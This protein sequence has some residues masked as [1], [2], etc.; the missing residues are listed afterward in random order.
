MILENSFGQPEPGWRREYLE[1]GLWI[2]QETE[3]VDR[4]DRLRARGDSS[5]HIRNVDVKAFAIDVC[6]ND[7][8]A[9]S[10]NGFRRRD[11]RERRGD[12]LVSGADFQRAQREDERV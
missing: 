4:N 6:E 3:Q 11:V 12:D 1:Q 9:D 10:V 2:A 7:F 5:R 8:C